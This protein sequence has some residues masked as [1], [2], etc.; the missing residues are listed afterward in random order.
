MGRLGLLS[1]ERLVARVRDGDD[2]AFEVLFARHQPGLLSFCRYLLGSRDE[3]EDAVQQAFLRLHR[4]LADGPPPEELRPYLYAIARNRCRTLLA[5]RRDAGPV[6]AELPDLAGLGDVVHQREELRELV[7]AVGRLPEDQRA[8]LVL[9]ELGDL[10]HAGIAEVLDVPEAKVRTL[11]YQ[12]KARLLADREALARPCEEV[13]AE[14]ATA[15][16]P[17][18]RRGPL[19]RH[20]RGCAGCRA[21]RAGLA[22][23]D[24]ALGLV[25][26]VSASAGLPAAVLSALGVGG[27]GGV[28][29]AGGVGGAAAATGA[30]A[31]A[32]AAAGG[33]GVLGSLGAAK[34]L[35]VVA[36]FGTGAAGGTV[37]LDEVTADP[38]PRDR[39]ARVADA[40]RPDRPPTTTTPL[41]IGLATAT[42][43]PARRPTPSPPAA[44]GQTPSHARGQT[45]SHPAA[46][47][48]RG[49][50]P[51]HARGQ[52]PSQAQGKDRARPARGQAPGRSGARG[53]TPSHARGQT[54]SQRGKGKERGRPARGQTP[55]HPAAGG[56][57]GQTPS[58]ARGQ[59]PSQGREEQGPAPG[60]GERG[61]AK[62]DTSPTLPPEPG[63]KGHE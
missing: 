20:L 35:A 16:G 1:D 2:R 23:Q 21:F 41:A 40:P 26:P 62:S 50:T 3:A 56:A 11:V 28:G 57:R 13:R 63:G 38:A 27:V 17:A 8:A 10:S 34:T 45:P 43:P 39:P 36:A 6:D 53:Q 54:P 44:R 49:Q 15:T 18:L 12:A 46:G 33:S 61:R 9:A 52:A 48:A 42:T 47:G 5:Q 24:A 59:T 51:S 58:H 32:G 7:A 37:V 22:R 19:R 25:L 60:Q 29:A 30:G 14:L 55:S 31:G 4:A